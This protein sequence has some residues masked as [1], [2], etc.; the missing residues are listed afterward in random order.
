MTEFL[1][2]EIVYH[3][4]ANLTSAPYS[5]AIF[6]PRRVKESD[7]FPGKSVGWKNFCFIWTSSFVPLGNRSST[8]KYEQQL[9]MC[10]RGSEQRILGYLT[11]NEFIIDDVPKSVLA[12]RLRHAEGVISKRSEFRNKRRQNLWSASEYG[13]ALSLNIP[14]VLSPYFSKFKPIWNNTFCKI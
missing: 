14:R 12:N 2:H 9:V 6:L 3:R 7:K 5:K 8:P 10:L 4:L 13:Y 11:C 1:I